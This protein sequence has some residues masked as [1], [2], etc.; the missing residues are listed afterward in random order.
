MSAPADSIS[1]FIVHYN[2]VPWLLPFTAVTTV[3]AARKWGSAI[4]KAASA[5]LGG[6]AELHGEFCDF[7]AGCHA[8]WWRLKARFAENRRPYERLAGESIRALS[9]R[10]GGD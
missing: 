7:L 8:N 9:R 6:L 5:A 4:K 10:A 1:N 3:A 2:L